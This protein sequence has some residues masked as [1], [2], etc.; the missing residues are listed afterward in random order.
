MVIPT[1]RGLAEIAIR[2]SRDA[3]KVAKYW[4]A[5]QWYLET[6]DDSRLKPFVNYKIIDASGAHVTLVTDLS[7]LERLGSAGVLSF[8]SI[9]AKA[10]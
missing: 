7:E 10:A 8:E 6:G 1:E 2:G 5:V 3:S 4:D 9:Y